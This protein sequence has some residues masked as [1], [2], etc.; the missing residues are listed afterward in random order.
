MI[1]SCLLRALLADAYEVELS[2][3]PVASIV[4]SALSEAV[5]GRDTMNVFKN[6]S[7]FE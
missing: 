7:C 3:G 4:A 1:L 2:G 5:H 6:L